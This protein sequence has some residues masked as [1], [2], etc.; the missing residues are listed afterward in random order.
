MTDGLRN[1]ERERER[2]RESQ[3]TQDGE[4]GVL[5]NSAPFSFHSSV[6]HFPDILKIPWTDT[7]MFTLAQLMKGNTCVTRW[8]MYRLSHET[9]QAP[10]V[11]RNVHM[12]MKTRNEH[13]VQS[14]SYQPAHSMAP[15]SFML[16]L[17]VNLP[18]VLAHKN[19]WS[20]INVRGLVGSDAGKHSLS[21]RSKV[22][23]SIG[24]LSVRKGQSLDSLWS[25]E[26]CLFCSWTQQ[27]QH[28]DVRDCL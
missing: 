26:R 7:K 1:G 2:T 25:T 24:Q 3:E 22:S 23:A 4:P 14:S 17:L 28:A 5:P 10:T 16:L 11:N 8:Y 19:L 18:Q 12:L 9:L 20:Q 6:P 15:C 21:K 13:W 27:T